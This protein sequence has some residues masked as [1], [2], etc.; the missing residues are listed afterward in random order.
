MVLKLYL[1]DDK[2]PVKVCATYPEMRDYYNANV[3]KT[4]PYRLEIDGRSIP[5]SLSS[6]IASLEQN[7]SSK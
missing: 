1:N 6:Y 4:T 3:D 7:K 5:T 2:E